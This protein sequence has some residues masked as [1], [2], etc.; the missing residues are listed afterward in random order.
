M[1]IRR[2]RTL[3]PQKEKAYLII[4]PKRPISY[5]L[6]I[7]HAGSISGFR[8]WSEKRMARKMTAETSDRYADT[9]SWLILWVLRQYYER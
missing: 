9:M 2:A 4:Q 1:A 5:S 7:R 3:A 8:K 6:I